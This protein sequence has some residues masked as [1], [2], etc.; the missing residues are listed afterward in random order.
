M[1]THS[2]EESS[3]IGITGHRD[4]WI[5]K[6]GIEQYPFDAILMVLNAAD[7]H[8]ASFIDHLLPTA[9]EKGLAIIGM[10]IPA[11]GWLSACIGLD[12]HGKETRWNARG[13]ED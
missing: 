5:L 4:P 1:K 11:H 8:S 7:K 10:K 13:R 12:L 6:K 2:A 3:F 9:V